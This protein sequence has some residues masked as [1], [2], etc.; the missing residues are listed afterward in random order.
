MSELVDKQLFRSFVP[1]NALNPDNFAELAG[2]TTTSVVT[3][4]RYI[5]KKGDEDKMSVY[6]V[7][8]E[9][10]L[11][12]EKGEVLKKITAGSEQAKHP[13]GH[14]QP[15]QLSAKV[16]KDATVIRV[17]SNLLDIMLTWDQTGSYDVV[18]IDDSESGEEESGDWMTKLLQ[19]GA[20]HRIP[21]A[22][23]QTMFMTMESVAYK[24]GEI[25]IK[26]GDEGDYFYIISSGTAQVIRE[27][28]KKPEG[29]PLAKL[30]VGDSFGEEA[31]IS[32]AKRNATIKMLTEGILMRLSKENFEKLLK[33][34][35]MKWVTFDEAK[36]MVAQGAKLIDV[37]L[38]TEYEKWHIKGSINI[39]LYFLRNKTDKLDEG[40]KYIV[41]CDTGRR[42]SS[43][44]YILNERGF[45]AYVM[46][47]GL[48]KAMP[49]EAA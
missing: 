45:D 46:Q 5:F 39:P 14:L 4:G 31:L 44:S 12:S 28:P 20:F 38:P 11:V 21:P 41:C 30:G 34:P 3:A 37:R 26:Q 9:V 27:T 40:A 1:I 43:A 7:D 10:D 24:P 22:N 29:V 18:E 48:A 36:Q 35:L 23:L 16:V 2:K 15:R 49:P 32:A 42:S 13:L 6:L 19:T 47:D 25:V 17:D 8:G 33:E